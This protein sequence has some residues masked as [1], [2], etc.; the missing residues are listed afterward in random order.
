MIYYMSKYSWSE[1]C[2]S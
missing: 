2:R 1:N